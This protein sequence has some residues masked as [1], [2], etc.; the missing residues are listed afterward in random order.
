M[1]NLRTL[2]RQ[3]TVRVS[4]NRVTRFAFL[5]SLCGQTKEKKKERERRQEVEHSEALLS[6]KAYTLKPPPL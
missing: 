1:P 5:T 4:E 6:G 2:L 3:S